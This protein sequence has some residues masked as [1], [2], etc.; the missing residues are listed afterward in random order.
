MSWPALV[1]AAVLAG[2]AWALTPVVLRALPE[3]ATSDA[4]DKVPYAA[5]ATPR[6][7]AA[8][9]VL[10]GLAGLIA[11]S[12]LGGEH[13][14]AWTA[15]ALVNVLACAIDARTTWLPARLAHAG[16]LVATVGA[17][18]V[19]LA[20]GSVWPLVRAG[21]GAVAVGGLFHLLWWVTGTLGYGDVRLA[22]TIG[23]VTALVDIELAGASSLAGTTLS[24]AVGIG[25]RL[26]GRHGGFPYGPGL[27][28]GPFVALLIR[29]PLG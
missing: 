20:Q 27:L 23:A 17:M 9:G 16:W 21:L 8:V 15:L 7:A 10:G 2:V 1:A 6:F 28:A 12:A 14:L 26:T 19:A 11:F 5:L 18:V 4:E 22:A 24:A 25:H 29:L 13:W 3:P